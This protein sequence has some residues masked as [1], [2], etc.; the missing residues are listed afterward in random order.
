MRT[1]GEVVQFGT[2]DQVLAR[3]ADPFV[4]EFVG[5]TRGIELLSRR[6]AE[7][8]PAIGPGPDGIDGWSVVSD[9]TGRP[10]AWV[11][12]GASED[13]PVLIE[14]VGPG[15]SMRDLLDSAL[16]SPAGAAVRV[17]AD[18]RLIGVVTYAALAE[19]LPGARR[20]VG[21]VR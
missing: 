12:M 9:A 7:V 6:P 8:V 14:P 3:P 4:A 11:R 15:G 5:S 1:P 21:G 20:E 10:T 19:H 17:D 16:V 18:G 2:P 13:D